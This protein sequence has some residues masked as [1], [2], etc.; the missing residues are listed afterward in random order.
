MLKIH[1][2][3]MKIH[4]GFDKEVVDGRSIAISRNS[5]N[6][7]IIPRQFGQHVACLAATAKIGYIAGDQ[8][9]ISSP[10]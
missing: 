7:G 2:A 3:A 9:Q 1:P 5:E 6:M 4:T 8:D 10:D